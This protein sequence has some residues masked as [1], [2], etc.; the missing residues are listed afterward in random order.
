MGLLNKIDKG[1]NKAVDRIDDDVTRAGEDDGEHIARYVKALE[2]GDDVRA[3]ALEILKAAD[4]KKM[5]SGRNRA[6]ACVYIA[7]KEKGDGKTWE[8][9]AK[10]ARTTKGFLQDAVKEIGEKTGIKAE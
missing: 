1:I 4:D 10:A 5:S 9:V 3:R 7:A 2:L 8:E 6:G